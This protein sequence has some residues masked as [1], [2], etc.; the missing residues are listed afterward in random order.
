MNYLIFQIQDMKLT[1]IV[2]KDILIEMRK[3]RMGLIQTW[4]QL[5]FSYLAIIKGIDK[6]ELENGCPVN[7]MC[8]T[9]VCM[10]FCVARVPIKFNF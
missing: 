1:N 5:R 8:N 6:A 3:Y 2:V 9:F 4:G 7:E 10:H